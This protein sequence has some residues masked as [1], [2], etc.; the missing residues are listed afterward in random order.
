MF[1][2]ETFAPRSDALGT[3]L[4]LAAMLF[5]LAATAAL[6]KDAGYYQNVTNS[7]DWEETEP[8]IAINPADSSKIEWH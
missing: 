6:T 4:V 2:S 5:P 7:L 8:S 3:A 1:R